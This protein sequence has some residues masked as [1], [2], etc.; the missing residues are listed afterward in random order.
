[1]GF[2]VIPFVMKTGLL[3]KVYLHKKAIIVKQS[4]VTLCFCGYLIFAVKKSEMF[5]VMLC[6]NVVCLF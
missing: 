3:F 2:S 5:L 1:M 4:E 6:A